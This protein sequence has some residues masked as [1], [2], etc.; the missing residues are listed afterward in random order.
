MKYKVLIILVMSFISNEIISQSDEIINPKGK[1][2]FGVEIGTN[3]ITSF[4]NDESKNSFQGGILTEYYFA[5]YW[6]LSGRLKYYNTGVSFYRSDSNTGGWFNFGTDEFFGTFKGAV[7]SIPMN[8]KWEFRIYKNLRGSLKVGYAYNLE[9]ASNYSNYS[10]NLNTDFPKQYGS[11]NTGYG[12]NYFLNKNLAV[13]AD[14]EFY[15]GTTKGHRDGLF[16]KTSYKTANQLINF[17][18]KYSFNKKE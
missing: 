9:T 11:F 7:L 4:S 3:E 1:W 2:F 13:Y 12:L 5:K 10:E 18:I 15:C 8:I 17:G 16:G 14:V 6:S